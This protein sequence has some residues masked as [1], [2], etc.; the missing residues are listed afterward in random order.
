M[1]RQR[2]SDIVHEQ[3]MISVLR[4]GSVRAAT[5]LMSDHEIGAVLVMDEG[6]LVSIFTERDLA[7]RVVAKGLDPDATAVG[8]VSTVHPDTLTPQSTPRE[9][10]KLMRNGHYR[11]LPIVQGDRVVGIVSIRDLHTTIMQSL[12]DDILM[13]AERLIKG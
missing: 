5:K 12:E 6:R 9:A 2:I 7:F 13:M 4:T 3:T 8:E 11:H 10:L 1:A